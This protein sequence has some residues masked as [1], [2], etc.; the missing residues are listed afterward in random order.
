MANRIKR[1]LF[2]QSEVVFVVVL[3]EIVRGFGS[4]CRRTHLRE[5]IPMDVFL[6]HTIKTNALLRIPMANHIKHILFHLFI[7]QTLWNQ[8]FVTYSDGKPYKTIAFHLFP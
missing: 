7:W 4:V 2:Q 5:R 6:L 8:C 1:L 3:E